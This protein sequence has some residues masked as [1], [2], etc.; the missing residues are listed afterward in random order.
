MMMV[1]IL[2]IIALTTHIQCPPPPEISIQSDSVPEI[3]G[4]Y[5]LSDKQNGYPSYTSSHG[6][7]A[8]RAQENGFDYHWYWEDSRTNKSVQMTLTVSY[9]PYTPAGWSGWN[10][11]EADNKTIVLY[12]GLFCTSAKGDYFILKT[13]PQF[14]NRASDCLNGVDEI[15]CP[16]ELGFIPMMLITIGI[17]GFGVG[18][19]LVFRYFRIM[20]MQSTDIVVAMGR[21]N[22]TMEE[23]IIDKIT[24]GMAGFQIYINIYQRTF[25]HLKHWTLIRF[26]KMWVLLFV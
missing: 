8:V 3:T 7:I 22:N 24:I 16:L 12:G 6:K 15:D 26:A 13:Y 14:C 5:S 25:S 21:T 20:D 4:L 11:V 17:V 10:I 19:F 2:V 1:P 18:L 23:Q 9:P